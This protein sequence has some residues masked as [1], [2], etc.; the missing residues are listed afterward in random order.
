MQKHCHIS[1]MRPSEVR[2]K[3]K[4]DR[5]S[6]LGLCRLGLTKKLVSQAIQICERT[7]YRWLSGTHQT[8]RRRRGRPM[9]ITNEI[10]AQILFSL[11]EN[12]FQMQE[13]VVQSLSATVKVHQS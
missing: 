5:P 11:R 3:I 9:K 4:L 1:G 8:K 10:A 6:I 7:I 13:D 2:V 12:P